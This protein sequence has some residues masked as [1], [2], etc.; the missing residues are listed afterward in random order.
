MHR[1]SG[2]TRAEIDEI[3]KDLPIKFPEALYE[4]Y[5]WSNRPKQEVNEE[6]YWHIFVLDGYDILPLAK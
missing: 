2:L 1:S 5:Q 6:N 3:T 4:L